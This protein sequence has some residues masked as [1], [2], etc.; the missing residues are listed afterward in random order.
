MNA[1]DLSL[2][3][4]GAG[5]ALANPLRGW[6]VDRAQIQSW[7]HGLQRP[8]CIL[9][10]PDGTVWTADA[11]GVMRIDANG[12]QT[13]IRQQQGDDG[14]RLDSAAALVMGGSLPNGIAFNRA[15]DIVIANF[16]TDAIE[17]MT[18]DGAS[19]TLYTHIDGVPLGKTNFV[20]ADSQGRLWFTVT[21]RQVPWTRSINEKTADGYVGLIDVDG[22]IR[23]VAYGFVGTNECRLDAREEW[24]YVAETNALRI[25]K[26]RVG[27]DG[28][29]SDRQV[30]GPADLG[31]FPD[32]FALD[33][34]G[35]LWVTLIL[36]ERLIAITPEGEVLTL[37][38]DGNPAALAVYEQHY[39]AGTT[40]PE[41][42]GACK[43]TLAPM[44]ASIAF[45]GP[46]LRTV[47]LGSLG[48]STL[49]RFRSPVPGLPP[50]HWPRA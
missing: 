2:A 5:D 48:G 19:R 47:Y 24:L 29:L 10:E 49:P 37:L 35:N 16:G 45:G 25:S 50:A 36:T 28:S 15:G 39:Q 1:P 17:L 46:D 41:L 20:L 4:P 3:A 14:R 23:I 18:R 9:T 38:D 22:R 27:A 6:Q 44:M 13:L 32:G 40:T 43:G 21:T 11:R 7:G 26:L 31:G 8:E 42:M 12:E 30:H 33:A 34:H